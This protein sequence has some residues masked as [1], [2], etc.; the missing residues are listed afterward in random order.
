MFPPVLYIV[1]VEHAF[2]ALQYSE[3]SKV[4]ISYIY[5]NMLLITLAEN[6]SQFRRKRAE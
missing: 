4:M 3:D 2:Q 6:K 1:G 5:T